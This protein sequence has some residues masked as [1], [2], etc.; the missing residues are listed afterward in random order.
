MHCTAPTPLRQTYTLQPASANPPS[1]CTQQLHT[2]LCGPADTTHPTLL[3][4]PGYRGEKFSTML[5]EGMLSVREYG[6]SFTSVTVTVN[7][8]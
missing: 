4:A 7:V 1:V 2:S 5:P 6:A 3:P 8:D